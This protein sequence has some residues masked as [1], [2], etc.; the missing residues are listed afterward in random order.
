VY[1]KNDTPL[2]LLTKNFEPR[3]NKLFGGLFC[4]HSTTDKNI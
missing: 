1:N 2:Q 3:L 4:C